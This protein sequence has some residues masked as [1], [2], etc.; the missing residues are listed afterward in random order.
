MD[1]LLL[2]H[3]HYYTIITITIT[4]PPLTTIIIIIIIL[5]ATDDCFVSSNC[6]SKQQQL[7]KLTQ[8]LSGKI[9]K[10]QKPE[11]KCRE[12]I[13]HSASKNCAIWFFQ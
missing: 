3:L 9:G 1:A 2:L 10:P 6:I 11:F 7:N 13:L 5:I 12:T 8:I 4:P